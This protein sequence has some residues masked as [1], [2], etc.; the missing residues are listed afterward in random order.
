MRKTVLVAL[1]YSSMLGAASAEGQEGSVPSQNC[2]IGPQERTYGKTKWLLYGCDGGSAAVIVPTKG[3]PAAPFF[4]L[5]F[6]D[7]GSIR[8]YG[9]GVGNKNASD[10]A[11]RELKSLP[12]E[13]LE[14]VLLD[15]QSSK[16]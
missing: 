13:A 6:R 8:I 5:V 7:G 15:A 10:A 3:N 14:K 11:M 2:T 12:G 9:E 16:R 4:F 1:L